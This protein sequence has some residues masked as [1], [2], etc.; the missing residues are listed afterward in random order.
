MSENG[1]FDD[2]YISQIVVYV[3]PIVPQLYPSRPSDS[4]IGQYNKQSIVQQM[5]CHQT[6]TRTIKSNIV[7]LLIMEPISWICL[8]HDVWKT[9]WST[10]TPWSIS[11]FDLNTRI[12]QADGLLNVLVAYPIFLAASNGYGIPLT[13]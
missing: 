8:N 2:I 13:A 11:S 9:T 1:E 7:L 5:A 3:F 6:G 10:F 12:V 4:Y